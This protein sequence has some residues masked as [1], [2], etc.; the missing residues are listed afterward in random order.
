METAHLK[1]TESSELSLPVTPLQIPQPHIPVIGKILKLPNSSVEQL[2]TA[3][4]SSTIVAGPLATSEQIKDLVPSIPLEDLIDIVGTL[5]TLYRVRDV[6][7][8]SPSG[9]LSSLIEGIRVSPEFDFLQDNNLTLLRNRFQEL[10]SI[11]ALNM[12]SKASRLQ[13]EGERLY[14]DST[15]FSDIRP[16]FGE[17]VKSRP[18]GAV[19]THTLK[20]GYHEGGEHHEFFLVLDEEDL[21]S[22]QETIKRA[23]TK[24]ETLGMLLKETGLP[25]LGR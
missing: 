13:R 20:F 12:L 24:G 19:I 16:V 22:L 7:E 10:L 1:T 6:I 14:C 15:I 18:T 25:R 11:P 23:Q 8:D 17:D 21:N 4:S 2:I 9:F 3:L 5:Y